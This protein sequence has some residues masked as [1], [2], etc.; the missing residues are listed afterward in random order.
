MNHQK[1]TGISL[2]LLL[3]A[4]A[5]AAEP[6]NILLITLDT[7]RADHLGC[8][9]NTKAITP[10]LDRLA[11]EGALF[12]N[13]FT[14]APITL[15]AHT[16]ILTG[17]YPFRT[18]VRDNGV[19][20]VP[21]STETLAEMLQSNHY[22]TF[23]FVSASVLDRFFGL[24]QGFDLYEDNISLNAKGT[25]NEGQRTASEVNRSLFQN[26]IAAPY[27]LWVHYYD[28]HFPYQ[29]PA[30]YSE[31]FASSPYDGE[32]AYV[33][34][35]I[36]ALLDH[37]KSQKLLENTIVIITAD[38]G[39]GLG[40]HQ[41]RTH[42]VFL[43]DSTLHVPL[44]V[45]Y[46]GKIQPGRKI[47][48]MVSLVD[49]TPT[50]LEYAGL[51]VP[52]GLDGISL[53]TAIDKGASDRADVYAE[54]LLTRNVY[55]WSPIFSI[56][57]PEWAFVVAPQKE[58]Y[59][60]SSDSGQV[61]NVIADQKSVA[62]DL[63]KKLHQLPYE[64]APANRVDIPEDLKARLESLGYISPSNSVESSSGLDPKEGIVFANQLDRSAELA[65]AGKVDEAIQTLK[66]AIDKKTDG[67]AARYSLA[68]FYSQK[69][70]YQQAENEYQQALEFS[71]NPVL[72][73]GL[74]V[75]QSHEG[76]LDSARE[77]FKKALT[78][79]PRLREAYV[80]WGELEVSDH[81]GDVFLDIVDAAISQ[82][83]YEPAMLLSGGRLRASRGQF[84]NSVD[85]YKKGLEVDEQ[86]EQ[87]H[88]EL[89]KAYHSLEQID[90]CLEQLKRALEINPNNSW[91]LRAIAY[92]YYK[93]KKDNVHAREYYEKAL[94]VNP[95]APDAEQIRKL[96]ETFKSAPASKK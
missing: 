8:Y 85:Y 42:G 72:Y 12:Q 62:E 96:L 49:I 51:K 36:Q 54:T 27:F 73:L 39:E 75:A 94:A 66:G 14:P 10:T 2:A 4:V 28:A 91:T 60:L 30:P 15:P 78:I 82:Q 25:G 5:L 32:I 40:D 95:K 22:H 21:N 69:G 92:L 9:G 19:S 93:E 64:N 71:R 33:D 81:R 83:V 16:S 44:I 55:G 84:Q 53:K 38:H 90:L 34:S 11:S 56:R 67:F 41:E 3:F 79:N 47:G 58:L 52:E 77:N 48:G 80:K 31:K 43:Y 50:I 1:V 45:W 89:S 6:S 87:L 76:K 57:N 24:N 61:K 86:S 29:P 18:G 74:A 70:D 63:E 20:S 35:Q 23:G 65:S 37:L 46:L 13:A 88:V 68:L 59:N 17:L 26:K 7:T